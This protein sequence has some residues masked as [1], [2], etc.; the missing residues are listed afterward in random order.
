MDG[1][2]DACTGWT[3]TVERIHTFAFTVPYM[4]QRLSYFFV[5]KGNKGQFDPND[6]RNKKIGEFCVLSSCSPKAHLMAWE[7]ALISDL[8]SA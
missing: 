5:K 8:P 2:Y 7:L 1:W 6:L 3:P 4:N